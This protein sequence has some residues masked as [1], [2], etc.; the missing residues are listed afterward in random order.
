VKE[1]NNN[2][3]CLVKGAKV[4]AI[5]ESMCAYCPRITST[6]GLP[7]ISF[8]KRKP[9]PLGLYRCFDFFCFLVETSIIFIFTFLSHKVLNSRLQ[10]VQKLVACFTWNFRGVKLECQLH[11]TA[12]C[13][14]HLAKGCIHPEDDRCHTLQGDAWFGSVKAAAA[15]GR[16]RIRA[17]LQVKNKKGFFPKDYIE[18][19]LE[20]APGG[21][22]IV[23]TGTAPNS[24]ELIALGYRYSTKTTLFF[25]ATANAGSTRPGKE[26]EMKY[27]DD[28]GNVCVHLVEHPDIISN[29]FEDSNSI[30]KHN[31]SRQFDLVLEKTWLT[32]DPFFRLAITLIGMNVV[33]TWKLAD[34]HKLLNAPGTKE[35]AKVTIKNLPECCVINLLLTPS[36]LFPPLHSRLL[37]EINLGPTNT[38]STQEISELTTTDNKENLHVPIRTLKDNNG[39]LHHLSPVPCWCE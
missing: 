36:H 25:V 28:H 33:D 1:F 29:F 9:E 39:L 21:V 7:K 12:A 8:I 18:K 14:L 17:V 3:F 30:D 15:L 27:T 11:N 37:A 38:P 20:D 34:N 19:V 24:I 35:E 26:Y 22:H 5:D 4:K 23:L 32:E 13:T 2:R 6:G 31:Q 10:L 16:K